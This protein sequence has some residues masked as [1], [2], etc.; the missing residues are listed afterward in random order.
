[1]NKPI[2]F[3]WIKALRSG[4]YKQTKTYLKREVDKGKFEYC[5]LGVLCTVEKIKNK[6]SLD[7]GYEFDGAKAILTA[8]LLNEFR[9]TEKQQDIL[10]DMNDSE[11]KNFKEIA[12]YIEKHL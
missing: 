10:T 8:T 6:K 3:K 12:D 11:N 4:R 2:K 5:C 1:M 7:G 9:L